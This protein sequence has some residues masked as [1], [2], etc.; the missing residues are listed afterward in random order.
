MADKFGFGKPSAIVKVIHFPGQVY[1]VLGPQ[2]IVPGQFHRSGYAYG[3]N[4][5]VKLLKS[6][7]ITRVLI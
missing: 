4:P 6:L 2:L 7:I 5:K 3:G 1:S